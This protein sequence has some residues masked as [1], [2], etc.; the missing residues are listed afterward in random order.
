MGTKNNAICRSNKVS[1]RQLNPKQSVNTNKSQLRCRTEATMSDTNSDNKT[2]RPIIPTD[3]S[4][5]NGWQ[6]QFLRRSMDS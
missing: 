5:S 6:W 2:I 3:T 4:V 1:K